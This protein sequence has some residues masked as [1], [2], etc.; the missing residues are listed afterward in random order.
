M[1]TGME[2]GQG[3]GCGD[4]YGNGKETGGEQC[5]QAAEVGL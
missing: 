1:H 5:D 3:W 4:T 2:L